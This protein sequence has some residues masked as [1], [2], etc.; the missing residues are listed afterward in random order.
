MDNCLSRTAEGTSNEERT[1]K[2]NPDK[3]T[4]EIKVMVSDFEIHFKK[5]KKLVSGF[6]SYWNSWVNR[7]IIPLIIMINT[8][9]ITKFSSITQFAV[10]F[11]MDHMILQKEIITLRYDIFLD[12]RSS[13][14]LELWV[15][16][17]FQRNISKFQE[18]CWMTSSVLWFKIFMWVSIILH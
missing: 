14:G 5:F 4:T 12:A 13:S 18:L 3:M 17:G 10:T 2:R 16:I 6:K 9:L 7:F 11:H 15:G 1:T 8:S